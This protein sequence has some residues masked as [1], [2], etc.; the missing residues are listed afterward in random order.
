MANDGRIGD[1]GPDRHWTRLD[2]ESVVIGLRESPE[3]ELGGPRG[4]PLMDCPQERDCHE[5][6]RRFRGH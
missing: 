2:R 6:H 3:K 1:G 5:S 4:L